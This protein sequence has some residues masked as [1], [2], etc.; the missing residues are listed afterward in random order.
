MPSTNA[1]GPLVRCGRRDG[2][3]PGSAFALVAG[4]F[5]IALFDVNGRLYAIDDGC[6]R[7]CAPLAAGMVD[8]TTVRCACG[9]V[10][11]LASGAVVGLPRLRVDVYGASVEGGDVVVALPSVY[12]GSETRGS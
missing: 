7:C 4:E 1:R 10:Y 3:R 2:L 6:L 8:G 11:E 12:R 5:S 9:W